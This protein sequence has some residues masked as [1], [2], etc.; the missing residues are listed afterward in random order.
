MLKLLQHHF[1]YWLPTLFQLWIKSKELFWKIGKP[2]RETVNSRGWNSLNDL[3]IGTLCPPMFCESVRVLVC[4]AIIM[5]LAAN[6]SFVFNSDLRYVQNAQHMFP[7]T[8][9]CIQAACCRVT[10]TTI[11]LSSTFRIAVCTYF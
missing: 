10:L 3:A 2:I 11:N 1:V 5:K 7:Y 4:P 6:V 9:I 8:I